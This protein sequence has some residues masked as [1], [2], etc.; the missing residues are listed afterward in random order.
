MTADVA[1]P[2]VH[3]PKFTAG[4]DLLRR[5]GASEVQIRWSDDDEPTVWFVVA[6]F[7]AEHW[8]TNA[9]PDP[10][11]AVMRLCDTLINGGTCVHCHRPSGFE[12]DHEHREADE[13]M[14]P[15]ICWF[16]WDPESE[17]FKRGCE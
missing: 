14:L 2:D 9:A 7:D 17:S 16:V 12:E 1:P 13:L 4:L 11:S 5:S 6:I 15:M 10:V 8:E 3:S